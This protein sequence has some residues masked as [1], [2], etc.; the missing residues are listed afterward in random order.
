M[1]PLPHV[2]KLESPIL[3]AREVV[4][5]V[6][7]KWDRKRI[8]KMMEQPPRLAVRNVGIISLRLATSRTA[9]HTDNS[10]QLA[11]TGS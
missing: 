8:L 2:L 7:K 9:L 3:L 6:R 11:I 1:K 5:R 10:D 4:R